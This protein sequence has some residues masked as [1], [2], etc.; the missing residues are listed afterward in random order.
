MDPN[1]VGS[2]SFGILWNQIVS[3]EETWYAKPLVYT[4]AR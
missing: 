3:E 1:I 2:S 4:H